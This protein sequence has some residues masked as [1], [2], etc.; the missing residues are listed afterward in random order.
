MVSNWR[1]I[2]VTRRCNFNSIPRRPSG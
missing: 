2:R 1:G